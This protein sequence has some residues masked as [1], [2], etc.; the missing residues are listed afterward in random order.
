MI[1][2]LFVFADFCSI[3]YLNYADQHQHDDGEKSLYKKYVDVCHF[4]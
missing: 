3:S 2:R 4:G 1:V